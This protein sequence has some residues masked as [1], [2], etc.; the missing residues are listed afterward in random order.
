MRL[1]T[2][3]EVERRRFVRKFGA[4]SIPTAPDPA[5][6][7]AG[8]LLD[9]LVG[10]I[11]RRAPRFVLLYLPSIRYFD[12]PVAPEDSAAGALYREVAVRHGIRIVDLTDVYLEEF[13][14]TG[15]P[16]HGFSN[17]TIGTGHINARG[18]ALAGTRLAEVLREELP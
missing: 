1:S 16:C 9:S 15:Q 14:R 17:T 4:E 3:E 7:R 6:L 11:A 8:T 2:L 12:R 13:R 18:H 5:R 10:D